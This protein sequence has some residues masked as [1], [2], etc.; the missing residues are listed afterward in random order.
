MAESQN[1]K[2]LLLVLNENRVEYLIV[3][4]YAV[5]RYTE[6]RFTKDLDIWVGASAENAKQVYAALARFGAP[7][8]SDGVTE[9][10]FAVRDTIYQIGVAPIRVDILTSISGCEFPESW[11]RR[12]P[13]MMFGVP[14]HFISLQ[15]LIRNKRAAGRS[16]DLEHLELL[17]GS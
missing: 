3:G 2:E 11:E 7:V 1:F 8:R 10:T 16:S 14:I 17:G 13:G 15:D 6:P 9:E 4:G 12:M 5:M